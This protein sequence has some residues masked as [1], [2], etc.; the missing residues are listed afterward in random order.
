MLTLI[1]LSSIGRTSA[2]LRLAVATIVYRFNVVSFV[3]VNSVGPGVRWSTR[4]RSLDDRCLLL[5]GALPVTVLAPV[6]RAL[7]PRAFV[8]PFTKLRVMDLLH[9]VPLCDNGVPF[10]GRSFVTV[11]VRRIG[12]FA[13]T[14]TYRKTQVTSLELKKKEATT[15]TKWI[16][17]MDMFRRT[18]MVPVMFVIVCLHAGC[19][20]GSS[21]G[22]DGVGWFLCRVRMQY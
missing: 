2:F 12:L 8:L 6:D 4:L 1:M 16:R 11:H 3:T 13:G 18:S 22:C 7:M 10:M 14:A 9:G 17:R 15:K 20:N 5:D 19:S 21:V